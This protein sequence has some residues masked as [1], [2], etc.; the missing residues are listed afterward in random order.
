VTRSSL[1]GYAGFCALLL[2]L[3]AVLGAVGTYRTITSSSDNLSTFI[4]TS[5][6]GVYNATGVNLQ[7][8]IYDLNSSGGT[9]YLP[10][11]NITITSTIY[12][13]HFC[14]TIKG[15]NPYI[16]ADH[17]VQYGTVLYKSGNFNLLTIRGASASSGRISNIVIEDLSL[18]GSL[19]NTGHLIDI[20]NSSYVTIRNCCLDR[21]SDT[22][23]FVWSCYS[24]TMDTV[25]INECGSNILSKPAV[26]Y[27]GNSSY[28]TA[29]V[30]IQN[31]IFEMNRYQNIYCSNIDPSNIIQGCYF[32]SQNTTTDF[33]YASGTIQIIDNS[34]FNCSEY[35]IH[36]VG[37]GYSLVKGNYILHSWLDGMRIES[38][39]NRIV[40]NH[41]LAS[42]HSY[43]I[44]IDSDYNNVLD[45]DI[46]YCWESGVYLFNV[47]NCTISNNQIYNN[48]QSTSWPNAGILLNSGCSNN[49]LTGNL[50]YDYQAIHTQTVGIKL[51]TGSGYN[52]TRD[53]IGYKTEA[54]GN[55]SVA[56]NGTITH[57]L[58]TT[59]KCIIVACQN[60]NLTV[61][62]THITSTT[63][64]V[65]IRNLVTC[66]PPGT[67]AY[68]IYWYAKV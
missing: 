32:E 6:G 33:I 38:E 19:S 23:V 63:F 7:K 25:L 37:G 66:L 16:N 45:N 48:A 11:G 20:Q 30:R 13:T 46:S 4:T 44:Q 34:M 65:A 35:G 17:L 1:I 8:A 21:V 31:C 40:D 14:I 29:A 18:V 5:L 54:W 36:L 55:T 39:C 10:T 15:N 62:V 24:F 42:R 41:I 52:V 53:N 22:A 64:T 26:V 49:V 9:V 43:G 3:G 56:N 2:I 47:E 12:I 67:T 59:P 51:S 57:G 61:M 28:V 50:L 60:Y 27:N 58:A 68:Y